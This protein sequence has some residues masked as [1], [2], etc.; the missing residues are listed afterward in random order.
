MRAGDNHVNDTQSRMA[1]NTSARNAIA[2][3]YA[4]VTHSCML[5]RAYDGGADSDHAPTAHTCL[6]D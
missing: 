6:G 1:P 5:E 4:A 2:D 3:A